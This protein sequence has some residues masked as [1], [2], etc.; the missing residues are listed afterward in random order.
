[1]ATYSAVTAG[2]KDPESPIDVNLIGK[3]DQNPEAMIEGASGAPRIQTAA[4][5]QSGGSEAVTAAC[6][7]DG[8]VDQSKAGGVTA[9]QNLEATINWG[10]RVS[11][12]V[13]T[14]N[15]KIFEFIIPAD[16]TYSTY[17]GIGNY[18]GF[19]TTVYGRIYKNGVAYGTNRSNSS[20]HPDV[21]YYWENLDFVAGDTIEYWGD[22][23]HSSGGVN[24]YLYICGD[25]ALSYVSQYN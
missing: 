22:S 3:L 8:A 17:L 11:V 23:A 21:N 20:A 13:G 10:H 6:I 12:S 18:S 7:R 25:N 16:G 14:T 2:E 19:T 5:E 9:N 1:M 4:L 24:A 15:Q